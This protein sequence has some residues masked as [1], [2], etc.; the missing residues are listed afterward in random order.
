MSVL[1]S[2]LEETGS[3][4]VADPDAAK[5]D[6]KS[7]A[8]LSF[9]ILHGKKMDEVDELKVQDSGE[10]LNE[11]FK[12]CTSE[13]PAERPDFKWILPQI[14]HALF[15]DYAYSASYD[16][17]WK[18][19]D[20]VGAGELDINNQEEKFQCTYLIKAC[21]FN[22]SRIVKEL[23]AQGADPNIPDKWGMTALTWAAENGKMDIAIALVKKGAELNVQNKYGDTPL[24]KAIAC[25]QKEVGEYL[26]SL[27][28]KCNEEEYPSE[29]KQ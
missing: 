20:F 19:I 21:E 18:A 15:Q 17:D 23:L 7:L 27:G 25:D 22:R 28:A 26:H 16:L 24:D 6:I 29:W 9:N 1:V 8:R 10:I 13:D 4:R 5:R 14:S 3:E 11:F 12:R 2:N